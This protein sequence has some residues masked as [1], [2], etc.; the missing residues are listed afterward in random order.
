MQQLSLA[1][2]VL[3]GQ[4]EKKNTVITL[5]TVIMVSTPWQLLLQKEAIQDISEDANGLFTHQLPL[6]RLK[7]LSTRPGHHFFPSQ[8]L[9]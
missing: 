5:S 9:Q 6:L 7:R 2:K 1:E 4:R 8:L 3:L